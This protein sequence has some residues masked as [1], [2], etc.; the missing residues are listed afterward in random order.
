MKIVIG[1]MT[2]SRTG[3][4]SVWSWIRPLSFIAIAKMP[5]NVANPSNRSD[6]MYTGCLRKV[7]YCCW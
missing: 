5:V 1:S 7:G 6:Q 2:Q 4:N 3:M